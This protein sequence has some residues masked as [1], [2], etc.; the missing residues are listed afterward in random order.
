MSIFISYS[1][2]DKQVVDEMATLLELAFPDKKVFWDKRLLGGDYTDD[3]LR[4]EVRWCQ[5]FVFFAS[6][7][8]MNDKSYCQRELKWAK[9]YNKHIVPYCISVEP[10]EVVTHLGS[11][12]IFCIDA[13]TPDTGSFAK[14]CGSIYRVVTPYSDFHRKQMYLLYSIINK[15][16]DHDSYQEEVEV[17]ERG[18]ELNYAWTPYIDSPMSERACKEVLDI[19]SMLERLQQDWEK[20]EDEEKLIVKSKFEFAEQVIMDVGFWANEE[21]KQFGYLCFL[22]EHKK[23]TS[24]NLAL[25]TGNSHGLVNLPRYRSMLQCYKQ[26]E[27]EER[28]VFDFIHR[29]LTPE[30]FVRILQEYRKEST[31]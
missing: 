11:N 14:L 24:L 13:R 15:L 17:Y 4:E 28:E 12:N 29:T 30:E 16:D 3:K 5:V 18:Y 8:S 21:G 20:L 26:L 27:S 22:R 10:E 1:H 9:E 2:Y 7:N 6:N 31:K 19:L 25:D 23:F